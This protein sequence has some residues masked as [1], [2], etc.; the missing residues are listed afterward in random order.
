MPDSVHTARW[1]GQIDDQGWD[2]RL[3]PCYLGLPHPAL[4]NVA[5]HDLPLRPPGLDR[6]V[7]V[8]G[9]WPW[10]LTRSATVVSQ[11]MR[12][13]RHVRGLTV[14]RSSPATRL[15]RLI[16][17]W[18]PDLVQS[19]ELQHSAYLT[20]A[21]RQLLGER[22]PPWAVTNWGSDIY[23]FRRLPEH[24]EKIAAVLAACDYYS[25][26]CCRDIGLAQELGFRGETLPVFPNTGGFDLQHVHQLRQSGPTSDRRVVLIKGYQGWSGR[27]LVALRA[28]ALCAPQ[29]KGYTVA[30]YL[31]D[32]D[33][34]LAA[35][36]V[37]D[38]TGIP[39]TIIPRIPHE[40]MLR[41][42]GRARVSVGVGISDAIST[43][44]LEAMVMGSFPVQSWTSC[45]DEWVEDSRS[46]ILVPPNDPE[47]I[48][49]AIRRA[50]T[51]DAL[52][53]GAADLNW[54]TACSRLDAR[55]IKPQVVDLYKR[56]LG[57]MDAEPP[58]SPCRGKREG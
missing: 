16:Q 53:D 40:E 48:A 49:A 28:V 22:F 41:W 55:S 15:A 24:R 25:C 13:L 17:S 34:E 4:R 21:A 52:V 35:R 30:V 51:D 37:E 57:L 39:V 33:V 23:L 46:A 2:V 19:L 7:R 14:F 11:A 50:V 47:P 20:L 5:V 1:L 26:E 36:L 18:K 42:H 31:S 6:S 9:A 44:L 32:P 10:P 45:A 8:P 27:A 3:F 43:S 29:L 54:A 58:V 38:E 12:V 56:L